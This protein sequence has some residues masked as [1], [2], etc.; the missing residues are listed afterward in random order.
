MVTGGLTDGVQIE[1][2]KNRTQF[3]YDKMDEAMKFKGLE[4]LKLTNKKKK[5]TNRC[6]I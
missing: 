4:H 2:K 6:K 5:G 3:L 1:E